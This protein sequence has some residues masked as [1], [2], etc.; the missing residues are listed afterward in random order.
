MVASHVVLFA[1]F[2]GLPE[3]HPGLGTWVGAAGAVIAILAAWS[4]ARAEYNRVQRLEAQRFNSEIALYQWIT[5]ESLS[6]ANQ[7]MSLAEAQDPSA[8]TFDSRH[9]NEGVYRRLVD[10]NFIPATQSPSVEAYDAFKDYIMVFLQLLQTP[11][12]GDAKGRFDSL[13]ARLQHKLQ[14]ALVGA[15]K[16]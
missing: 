7:Y 1:G 2:C 11:A 14:K 3:K 4:L 10:L 6:L 13:K 5:A 16:R 12:S 15:R 8:V 9:N